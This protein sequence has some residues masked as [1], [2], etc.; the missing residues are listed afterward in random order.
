MAPWDGFRAFM[1]DS[2]EILAS[3]DHALAELDAIVLARTGEDLTKAARPA[4]TA[5][6]NASGLAM[7]FE[8]SVRLLEEIAAKVPRKVDTTSQ[9]QFGVVEEDPGPVFRERIMPFFTTVREQAQ[10]IDDDVDEQCSNLGSVLATLALVISAAHTRPK[11]DTEKELT[12]FFEDL[13]FA[14]ED[15]D[16]LVPKA[17]SRSPLAPHLVGLK[18]SAQAVAGWT[19][20]VVPPKTHVGEFRKIVEIQ[21]E[22]VKGNF[23]ELGG[24]PKHTLMVEAMVALV[25]DVEKY[26]EEFHPAGLRW[27]YAKGCKQETWKGFVPEMIPPHSHPLADYQAMI[28]GPVADLVL[29]SKPFGGR[30]LEQAEQIDVVFRA[31]YAMIQAAAKRRRPE[32]PSGLKMLVMSSMHEIAV[33][34]NVVAET[35]PESP[36]HDHIALVGEL[37]A[38]MAWCVVTEVTAAT[39]VRDLLPLLRSLS[40][41]LVATHGGDGADYGFLHERW[42]DAYDRLAASLVLYVG[43]FHYNA[44]TF[45]ADYEVGE[46]EEYMARKELGA[47]MERLR[48]ANKGVAWESKGMRW[49]KKA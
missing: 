33:V 18:E 2:S 31:Q 21:A 47:M 48:D 23:L 40:A 29:A 44:L 26:V 1:L 20:S 36:F 5:F 32:N 34:M 35:P 38:L 19:T 9:Y 37:M 46:V 13:M 12:A 43:R 14:V 15:L 39:Y 41:K 45:D 30:L 11:P 8:N 17:S 4:P 3:L 22:I 27:N 6:K 7:K 24:D 10:L 42:A 49:A 16:D 28:K 25:Y